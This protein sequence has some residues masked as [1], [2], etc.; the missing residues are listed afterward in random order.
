LKRAADG[1]YQH[2]LVSIMR[3][4]GWVDR[5]KYKEALEPFLNEPA[6][7]QTVL[8]ILCDHWDLAAL[9][10]DELRRFIR[11]A[12]WPPS[13][14]SDPAQDCRSYA[15]S[16]IDWKWRKL[17]DPTLLREVI[18]IYRREVPGTRIRETAYRTLWK[19]LGGPYVSEVETL[20]LA[21]RL[22]AELEDAIASGEDNL[23][24]IS[25]TFVHAANPDRTVNDLLAALSHE[26]ETVRFDAA[27]R[28][29]EIVREAEAGRKGE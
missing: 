6:L 18:I 22:A 24:A 12:S 13:S 8:G 2:M 16:L 3:Y 7:A 5:M 4:A 10:K 23:R 11:G 21:E 9:Y 29:R 27:R 20:R 15:L 28:L 14:F 25:E 19:L 26:N 1:D 17:N